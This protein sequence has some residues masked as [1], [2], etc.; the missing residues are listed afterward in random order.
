MVD[1][2][3]LNILIIICSATSKPYKSSK[4]CYMTNFVL[5]C[6]QLP[7]WIQMKCALILNCN[8]DNTTGVQ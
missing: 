3:N 8:A 4:G 6:S 1:C 5:E 2:K 7:Y